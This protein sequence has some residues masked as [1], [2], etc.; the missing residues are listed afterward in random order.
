MNPNLGS[1]NGNDG[2]DQ[3]KL[4]ERERLLARLRL[5]RRHR[6]WGRNGTNS[7]PWRSSS[8]LASRLV[9]LLVGLVIFSVAGFGGIGLA[10]Y[11]YLM[12]DL[13]SPEALLE[14]NMFQSINIYD[15]NGVLLASLWD[16]DKGGRR[17]WTKLSDISPWVIKATLAAEDA[18]FYE[19]PGVDAGSIIRAFYR[20][21]DEGNI[22]S[23]ASTITMQLARNA[24]MDYEERTEQSYLRKLREAILAIKITQTLP[25]DTILEMYLNTV[26]YGNL[27]YSI[28]TAAGAY[29]DKPAKDLTLAEAAMLAGLPQAPSAYDPFTNPQQA[30][31]RQEWV[32]DSMVHHGFVSAEEAEAAKQE[33]IRLIRKKYDFHAPHF[34]NYVSGLLWDKYGPDMYKLGLEVYTTLDLGLQQTGERIVKEHVQSIS[35][36]N[37]TDGALVGIDPHTGEILT[38]VGSADYYDDTID[39]QVN[40]C[41]AERQPGSALKPFTYLTAILKKGVTPSTV[42][43]DRQIFF[44]AGYGNAYAPGNHDGAWHGPVTVRRALASSLNLPAVLMMHYVGLDEVLNTLHRFGITT[45]NQRERYGLAITLGGGE[46]RPLDLTYAYSVFANQGVQVGEE[47]P[48]ERRRFGYSELQPTPFKKILN[49]RG[50]VLYEYVPKTRTLISPEEAYL[51]TSILSDNEAQEPTY[52]PNN[53]L[54]MPRPAAAKTGTTEWYQ[55]S[56]TIGYTPDLVAGAWVGNANN[57]PM[58]RV[59]GSSGAGKIWN[60]YIQ[61]ALKDKPCKE[62]IIPPGLQIAEVWATDPATSKWRL[63]RDYFLP[64]RLPANAPSG[65]RS[66]WYLDVRTGRGEDGMPTVDADLVNVPEWFRQGAEYWTIEDLPKEPKKEQ[67]EPF[68]PHVEQVAN[69]GGL[70]AY[71]RYTPAP[72]DKM[73][74]LPEGTTV[75]VIEPDKD[76]RKTTWKHVRDEQGRDGWIPSYFLAPVEQ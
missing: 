62:F 57:Q 43:I 73:A 14:R 18:R 38:M 21:Y 63:R 19:N 16:R 42:L 64:E 28:G 54:L 15:R 5:A 24:L 39:G 59:V 1:Q 9:V 30:K 65:P 27:S 71:L 31:A 67:Q 69:T 75:T 2:H 58:K 22:T 20:N 74:L 13:P 61:E 17:T 36:L 50:D 23:G 52:G 6:R 37:A 41:L 66:G 33:T 72:E 45:L 53:E 46:I 12:Q 3:N 47:V 76:V 32:L 55:D 51:I 26:Y 29:Y 56:W 48:L 11:I 10:A 34:V 40:I 7:H 60:S 68:T 44:D 35:H 25:K 8:N 70:G 4:S 49:S